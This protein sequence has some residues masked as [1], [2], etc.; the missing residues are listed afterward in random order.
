MCFEEVYI[1][2]EAECKSVAEVCMLTAVA[3]EHIEHTLDAA[4]VAVCMLAV[5]VRYNA[6]AG[7][8]VHCNVAEEEGKQDVAD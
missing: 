6:V 8:E 4:E 5:A 2:V 3:V 1:E 7:V